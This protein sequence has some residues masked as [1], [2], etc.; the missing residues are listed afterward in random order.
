MEP[1]ADDVASHVHLLPPPHVPTSLVTTHPLRVL[2]I[3]ARADIGGGPLHVDLLA[4]HLSTSVDK[5]L[6]CPAERSVRSRCRP[7]RP[8]ELRCQRPDLTRTR[9]SPLGN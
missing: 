1:V 9:V 2:L 6:A 5:W 7:H 8:T 3:T 4:R